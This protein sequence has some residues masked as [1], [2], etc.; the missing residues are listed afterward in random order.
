MKRAYRVAVGCVAALVV[1]GALGMN[2][3]AWGATVVAG[4]GGGGGS[5][6]QLERAARALREG[7]F[8]AAEKMYR[9][10]LAKNSRNLAARLGL[11]FALVKQRKNLDAYDAAARVVAVDPL[12]ARAHALLGA[13]LLGSG[14]F[15]Q[16]IEE[17]RTALSFDGNDA[18]AVA[19]LAMVDFY[20]NRLTASVNG[21]RR[22]I[23]L[24][25]DEPDY[26]FSLG[27]VAA[28]SERYAEAADSYERFLRIAPRTDIDRRARIRGLIDFL[29]YLG[30]QGSLVRPT[31]PERVELPFELVNNRPVVKVRLNGT[32]ETLRFVIDTGAGMCVVSEKAARRVGL[33]PVARGGNA[34]AIGGGGRFEIVYGFLTS[35]QFGE[36]RV[37]N[38]P[39][40]IRQIFN[41]DEPVDGYI[42]LSVVSKYLASIDYGTRAM[43]LLRDD[44]LPP[45]DPLAKPDGIEIPIRTTSGGFWSGEIQIDGIE[46]PLNFIIDTG[47]TISVVSQAL[48]DREEMGRFAQKARLRVYGAAGIAEDVQ[49]LL[50]PRVLIGSQTRANVPAA[51]LDLD[52]INETAGFE[53]TG[54]IGGNV[55]RHFRVTFDFRRAVVRL[56]SLTATPPANA[57]EGTEAVATGHP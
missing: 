33:R 11:S 44:A 42:G 31:G 50:L 27:Q 28:R 13:A 49:T 30:T 46:K 12:S 54:I 41:D 19:G 18:L 35:M 15:Q 40:Y 47:A 8:E 22:A 21:L 20:E 39:I 57:A 55:L 25:G 56:E 4:G 45:F 17:F 6:K 52:S 43:T 3:T 53:Q 48:A 7:E 9:E 10:M 29:R 36:A 16:S 23:A 51:V 5:D 1:C 26:Y 2:R 38:V 37:E 32:K 34:R 24:D 14:D